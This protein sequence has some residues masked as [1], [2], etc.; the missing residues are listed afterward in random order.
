MTQ[1]SR[2]PEEPILDN[3]DECRK[4]GNLKRLNDQSDV[5]GFGSYLKNDYNLLQNLLFSD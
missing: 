4:N 1:W 2:R 5:C 3:N